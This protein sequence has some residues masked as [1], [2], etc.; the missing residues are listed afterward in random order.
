MEKCG[1]VFDGNGDEPGTIRFRLN[2]SRKRDLF[3]SQCNLRWLENPAL[4]GR[5]LSPYPPPTNE[6]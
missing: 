1:L 3:S 6:P 4:D 5:K 2:L